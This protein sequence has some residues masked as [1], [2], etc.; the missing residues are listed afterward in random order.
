MTKTTTTR[1]RLHAEGLKRQADEYA[2]KK[3]EE[4][5]TMQIRYEKLAA[6]R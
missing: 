1:L 6:C 3:N 5:T 4:A 2:K